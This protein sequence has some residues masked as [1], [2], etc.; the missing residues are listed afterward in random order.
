M[1]T[2]ETTVVTVNTG[3]TVYLGGS[4]YGFGAGSKLTVPAK[5]AADLIS[6]GS[7]SAVASAAAPATPAA[8]T[9]TGG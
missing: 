2:V 3:C 7:V 8:S 1:A 6:A 4:H 5:I 9:S